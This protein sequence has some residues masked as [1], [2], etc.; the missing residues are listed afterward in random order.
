MYL[1]LLSKGNT[2]E[3]V[4]C[5]HW[6][7]RRAL[8]HAHFLQQVETARNHISLFTLESKARKPISATLPVKKGLQ[9]DY[10]RANTMSPESSIK[11][12]CT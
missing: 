6:T 5:R 2:Q 4:I 10:P 12:K 8:R 7:G 1:V 11:K 3:T 9:H